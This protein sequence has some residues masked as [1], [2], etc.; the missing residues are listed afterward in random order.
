ML[1][2]VKGRDDEKPG[3][4]YGM[5]AIACAQAVLTVSGIPL[6]VWY[7]ILACLGIFSFTRLLLRKLPTSEVTDKQLTV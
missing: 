4:F 1:R 7:I 6:R 2:E 3:T 5:S